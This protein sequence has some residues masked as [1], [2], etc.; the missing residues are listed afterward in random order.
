[1]LGQGRHRD[2][3][4]RAQSSLFAVDQDAESTVLYRKRLCE[5]LM[6]MFRWAAAAFGAITTLVCSQPSFTPRIV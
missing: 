6:K 4:A 5:R 2:R 1:V 3:L